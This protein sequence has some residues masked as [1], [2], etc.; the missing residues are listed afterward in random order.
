MSTLESW[1]P[2]DVFVTCL[3]LVAAAVVLVSTVAALAARAFKSRAALRHSLLLSAL[4]CCLL[5]PC[6][7]AAI[8][9]CRLALFQLPLWPP[10]DATTAV[11]M[12]RSK[13]EIANNF[14]A[15][16]TSSDS[17]PRQLE[18]L[19]DGR[20]IDKS[21]NLPAAAPADRASTTDVSDEI[22]AESRPTSS[23][24]RRIVTFATLVWGVGTVLLLVGVARCCV[25]LRRLRASLQPARDDRL[26]D[27]LAEISR[28]LG[29][30]RPPEIGISADVLTP[31]ALG[32]LRPVIVLPGSSLAQITKDQLRDVLTHESAHI[33]RGD[34]RIVA[35]QLAAKALFWPMASIH[36]LN[37]QL[38]CAREEV[39]D[40]FVLDDRDPVRYG[41]T[42]LRLA[43]L[44][45][46]RPPLAASTGIL[47]WRGGLE[48]RIEGLISAKRNRQKKT[49]LLTAVALF[50]LFFA[51][52]AIICSTT[53]VDGQEKPPATPVPV[54]NTPVAPTSSSPPET[55]QSRRHGLPFDGIVFE[56]ILTDAER[57]PVFVD[58]DTGR[59]L[60]PPLDVL[61]SENR[62]KPVD[63]WIFPE[64]LKRWVRQSGIDLAVQ[65]DGKSVTLI[66]FD[67][68][69]GDSFPLNQNRSEDAIAKMV[70]PA[71]PAR[72]QWIT[73]KRR[74]L[75]PALNQKI[76]YVT[77]E[78]GLGTFRLTVSRFRGPNTI[79]FDYALARESDVHELTGQPILAAYEPQILAE[80]AGFLLVDVSEQKLRLRTPGGSNQ[81]ELG[82]DQVMVRERSHPELR[83]ARL[84]TGILEIDAPAGRV[85][86]KGGG[87][88]ATLRRLGN[89]VQV[90]MDKRI[91]EAD[92]F[93]LWMPQLKID[94]DSLQW[95]AMTPPPDD[96]KQKAEARRKN[97]EAG[98]AV[99]AELAEKQGYRL[100]P[101][102]GILRIA[103]PFPPLRGEYWRVAHPDQ[104]S[105]LSGSPDGPSVATY[106]WNGE[107]LHEGWITVSW[108][109][110]GLCD[111]IQRIKSQQISGP[112]GLLKTPLPGDWVFRAGMSDEVFAQQ[113]DAILRN[114]MKLP[115]HLEFREVKREVYVARGHYH[116]TPLPDTRVRSANIQIYGKAL[117]PQNFVKG[118]TVDGGGGGTFGEFLNWVGRWIDAPIVSD[119]A[120]PPGRVHW[121]LHGRGITFGRPTSKTQREAHDPALV[122]H[123]VEMQTGLHFTKE[124][125]PVKM[126]VVERKPL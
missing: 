37:R 118:G 100:A 33:L 82:P 92:Q 43:E 12:R 108:T 88:S 4:V 46:G 125:R 90:E 16:P 124:T 49:S 25:R 14:R 60:T 30:R 111:A 41:E 52:I 56:R 72:S 101:G 87:K 86:V 40:N 85:V 119:V 3:V 34:Q 54:P 35:L 48:S 59:W 77:R 91:A 45:H 66:G 8:V 122:L 103:P 39:C 9:K 15:T 7:A 71:R 18:P 24:L 17:E 67:L 99:M 6:F 95:K 80:L 94:D 98:A 120:A 79:H 78:G 75:Q 21:N 96:L 29:L 32:W 36:W 109:L 42:L 44:A 126:L 73:L 26:P 27:L 38:V 117:N 70:T 64:P 106:V 68:R 116:F 84:H 19:A 104:H 2:G 13:P 81:I 121:T 115:I 1:Y 76:P 55:P 50:A 51:S 83:A 20:A 113:F 107:L 58:I 22:E 11:E 105:P 5:S 110:G 112:A 65:T 62:G 10:G 97:R 89:R 57:E 31:L 74:L 53:L 102:Q 123:N 28:R 93:T 61:T 23:Q 69:F 63:Q 47:H 114:E